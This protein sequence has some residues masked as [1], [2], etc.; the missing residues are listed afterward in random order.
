M[1]KDVSLQEIVS[2]GIPE[3]GANREGEFLSFE[4]KQKQ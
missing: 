4:T 1:V 2:D 3:T